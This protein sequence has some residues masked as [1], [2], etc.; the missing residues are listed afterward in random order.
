MK[1]NKSLQNA[2]ML[3]ETLIELM[4]KFGYEIVVEGIETQ[5][6][7]EYLKKQGI[8]FAQGYYF[9]KPLCE[10]DFIEFLEKNNK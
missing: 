7:F 9:S 2:K 1:K 6:Q 8:T 3:L 10:N 5:E 4:L